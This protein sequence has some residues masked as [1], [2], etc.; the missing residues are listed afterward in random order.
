M[1]RK[2]A[3]VETEVDVISD[4]NPL[5]LKV[6]KN[7]VGT[8][9]TNI[10]QL[11]IYVT[12][13]LE[14]YKPELY[15]GDADSARKARAELNNA[16]KVLTQ[17]RI[18]IMKKVMKPYED[19]ELRCKAL[20]KN[21]DSASGLLDA[22]VKEKEE[23]EKKLKRMRCEELWLSRDFALFP[24]EKVFNPKWLNKGTKESDIT[25]EMDAIIDR[26]YKDLKTIEKFG[27]D[28]DTL[29]AH[30]LISLD[31]G[32]TLDYGEELA[33][34]KELAEEEA[35]NREQRE[36]DEV[37]KK[38]HEE[39]VR[40][41]W[42]SVERQPMEDLAAQALGMKEPPKPVTKE[43]VISIKAT[44]DQLYKLK[45]ACNALGIAYSVEELTF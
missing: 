4:L 27:T 20:E 32:E 37:I 45:M 40:E 28:A 29:K 33:K 5:E 42:E 38:Q 2:K 19:F 30:Y 26:T 21:V 31:I 17:T 10:E 14:E 18:N 1:A 41:S 22:I 24:L 13:K 7:V 15:S 39:L 25:D 43:F 6:I 9:E 16:K 23:Q 11:E 34:K 12:N 8:L 3:E 44:D 36:H 35:R